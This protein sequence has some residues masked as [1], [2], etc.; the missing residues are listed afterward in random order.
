[1][2]YR[3]PKR[4]FEDSGSVNPEQSYYVPLENVTNTKK[5]DIKTMVDL[6]RHFILLLERK[7]TGK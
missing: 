1:M 5:Q 4:I 7:V 3:K 6:G 2:K